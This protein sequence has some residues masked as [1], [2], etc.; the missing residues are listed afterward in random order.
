MRLKRLK[1]D[2]EF[3]RVYRHGR[4]V[5]SKN[6]VLY[7]CPNEMFINRLGFSI[8]KRVGNSVQRNRVRRIYR[9]AFY[10]LEEHMLMGHD[11]VLV[12]RKPAK[13]V[14]YNDACREL[15]S[16]CRK[17]KLLTK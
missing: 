5:V 11:F 3:K 4:T 12:A 13:D 15:L 1:K 8:S 2:Y 17:R 6:I 10:K 9:E 14:S 7:Y 16:L